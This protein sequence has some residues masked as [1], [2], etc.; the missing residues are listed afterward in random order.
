M[1]TEVEIRG[2]A[3]ELVN[4]QS[5]L[6]QKYTKAFDKNCDIGVIDSLSRE[7]RSCDD[8]MVTLSWILGYYN[9]I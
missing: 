5:D 9:L 7:I 3:R 8:K 4:R 6:Y 1:R 2:K